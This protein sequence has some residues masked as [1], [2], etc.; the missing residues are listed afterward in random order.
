MAQFATAG[1]ADQVREGEATAF[2]VDGT[3]VAVARVGGRL[4]AF[5]DI[6]T[7][8]GCNL[9]NGDIEDTAVVCE[10]HGSMFSLETGEV[11]QGPATDPIATYPVRE[12]G[13]ELQVQV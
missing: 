5:N 8:R 2:Q 6:C 11:L 7:H 1:P 12:E 3:D 10:C 4:F 9:S 13:S